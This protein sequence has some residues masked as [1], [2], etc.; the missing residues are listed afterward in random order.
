[1]AI[2]TPAA[3]EMVG[4]S[5]VCTTIAGGA[6]GLTALVWSRYTRHIYDLVVVCNGILAGLVAITSSCACVEPWAAIV[7]GCT[8]ALIFSACENIILEKWRVRC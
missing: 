4:R 2:T 5:G 6:A 8:G 7:I 3:R 1:M